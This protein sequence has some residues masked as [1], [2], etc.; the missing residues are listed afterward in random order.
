MKKMQL[1]HQYLLSTGLITPEQINTTVTEGIVVFHAVGDSSGS[2]AFSR[3]YV[4][5]VEI[6]AYAGDADKLDAAIV[7]WCGLYQPELAGSDNG[8]DFKAKIINTETVQL[9]VALPLTER[10]RYDRVKGE[11]LNCV[12]PLLL[13]E[14]TLAG[15]PVFLVDTVSGETT[16][17]GKLP[18]G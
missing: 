5:V 8:Y 16:V 7:W 10:V 15:I 12:T 9:T 2:V 6:T 4:A 3:E 17:V 13:D 14:A 18:N 1:L 11:M